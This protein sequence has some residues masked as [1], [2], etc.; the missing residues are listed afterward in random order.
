MSIV[1]TANIHNVASIKL[2][3]VDFGNFVSH[4]LTFETAD[5]STVTVSAFANQ[6]ISVE[7]T[8]VRRSLDRAEAA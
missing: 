7:E 4:E 2:R 1:S 6:R 8:D 3:V 5:G